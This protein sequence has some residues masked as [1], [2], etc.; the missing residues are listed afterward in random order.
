MRPT[1]SRSRFTRLAKWTSRATGKPAAFVIAVSIIAAWVLT[2]PLFGY[3]DTW[4]LVINTGTTIV[5]FLMVFLIQNTQNRDS[6]AIQVKLD[7]L[8][9]ATEGGLAGNADALM[10][11]RPGLP[12]AVFSADCVPILIFDPDGR[13]LAAVHAGWRGTARAVARAAIDALLEAGGTPDRLLAAVGPSIGPCCYEVDKP[14]IARLDQAFPGGW[15]AWVRSVGSGKWMLDLWDANE[16]HLR[17]AGLRSDRIDNPRLCTGCRTDLFYSY[18]RGHKGRLVTI[19]AVPL[20]PSGLASPLE[21][22]V[23]AR[24]ASLSPTR[25]EGDAAC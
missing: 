25:G 19:A 2:G 6:E 18:R 20:T 10:T 13:R 3:S 1:K 14:V 9:R 12:I 23:S 5:T 7:E 15:G 22:S 4:Q 24:N 8:I 16:D 17:G 11:E 21:V